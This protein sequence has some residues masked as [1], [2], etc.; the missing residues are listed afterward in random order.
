MRRAGFLPAV[1]YGE[2]IGSRSIAIPYKEFEKVRKEAGESTLV[3]LLIEEEKSPQNEFTVLIYDIKNDPLKGRLLHAD[4]Y[5]VRMDK[6]IHAKV[7]VAFEGESPAVK[8]EGGILVKVAHELEVSAL[9]QDLPHDLKADLTRLTAIKSRIQVKDISV[10][11]GV[12]IHADPEEII[13]VIEPPRSEEE[14][15]QAVSISEPAPAEVK[16]ERE[17]KKEIK[18][19]TEEKAEEGG[20]AEKAKNK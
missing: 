13:A 19:E 20:A 17:I 11:Q 9:P 7:P 8:N 14:L 10:P 5:A 1:V 2:G 3:K 18:K 4:F 6:K 15:A 12:H 16:T